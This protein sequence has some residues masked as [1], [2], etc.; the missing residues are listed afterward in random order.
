MKAGTFRDRMAS[1]AL[2]RR[3]AALL[4]GV[5]A[6][7]LPVSATGQVILREGRGELA[8]TVAD[9]GPLGVSVDVSTD[10][11]PTPRI[12]GWDRVKSIVGDRARGAEPF[13][14]L[15]DALWRA[16]ARLERGD[17]LGAEPLLIPLAERYTGDSGKGPSAAVVFDGLLRCRLARG[18]QAGSISAWLQMLAVYQR[19]G[20]SGVTWAPPA[21]WIGGTIDALPAVDPRT[22]LTPSLPP[23][24]VGEPGLDLAASRGDWTR[25]AGAGSPTAAE[26]AEWYTIAGR[27]EAGSAI[28]WPSK[29]S[30]AP[31]PRLVRLIVQARAGDA[32]QRAAARESILGIMGGD[33][34][35]SWE[36][37]WCRAALGRSLLREDDHEQKIRGVVQLLHVPARL[38]RAS[39]YLAGVCLAEAAT[40]M[41]ALGDV[42]AAVALKQELASAYPTHPALTWSRLLDIKAGGTPPRL[43][44]ASP[45]APAQPGPGADPASPGGGP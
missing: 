28:Q 13:I 19:S 2:I 23:I 36:E 30:D 38:S 22:G 45:S 32:A 11:K 3:G 9:V 16:R 31:G 7:A 8:G 29:W 41:W 10:G 15:S 35:E 6:L 39:P 44:A 20:V 43:A 14:P 18:A 34:A 37:A 17:W 42:Q 27:F 24:W 26:L 25:A 1:P 4:V 33:S 40:A 12:V 5:A 21:S